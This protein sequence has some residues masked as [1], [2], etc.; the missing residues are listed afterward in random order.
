MEG[1]RPVQPGEKKIKEFFEQIEIPDEL[2]SLVEQTLQKQQ[3][4]RKRGNQ[5]KKSF[6]AIIGSIAACIVIIVAFANTNQVFAKTLEQVP[7]VGPIIKILTMHSYVEENADEKIQADIP[8]INSEDA[9]AKTVNDAIQKKVKQHIAQSKKRI[10]EYKQAFLETGGTEEE[11]AAKK[12][13]VDVHYD[14][15]YQSDEIV[16]FVIT[17]TEDWSTAYTK[18]YFYN[19][20]LKKG[21]TIQLD[22]LLGKNAISIANQSILKQMKERVQ[23]HPEYSYF[24][25]KEGGFQ[26]IDQK[27]PF[28]INQAK[29]PVIVFEKYAIAP[30]FMG[31]QEFEITR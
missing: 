24:S 4:K 22:D 19:L 16:S 15:K 26:T 17:A 9:Y 12:I 18:Q 29:N 21:T 27:T 5:M 20:D 10:A 1:G 31:I 8:G 6:I 23:K 30:G 3:S 13:K 25:A 7:V 11:F 28:Y 2:P 14:I